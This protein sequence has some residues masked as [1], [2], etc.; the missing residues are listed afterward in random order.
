[1]TRA[2]MGVR[3]C[4]CIATRSLRLARSDDQDVLCHGLREETGE[5]AVTGVCKAREAGGVRPGLGL[6]PGVVCVE[7]TEEEK[8]VCVPWCQRCAAASRRPCAATS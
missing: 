3:A 5:M 2:C 6:R 7:R 1:M 4:L 8:A